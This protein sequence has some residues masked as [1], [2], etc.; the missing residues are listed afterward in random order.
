MTNYSTYLL[1]RT[2]ASAFIAA[3]D[4]PCN[5]ALEPIF[6]KKHSCDMETTFCLKSISNDT[7]YAGQT[8]PASPF[9]YTCLCNFGFYIPNQ[10]LHG[11]EGHIV[12]SG[13]G[14]YSCIR[15]PGACSSCNEKGECSLSEVHEY[16]SLETLLRFSIGVILSACMLCC[17]VLAAVVFKRRKCK[18]ISSGMWTVLE[19]I[20]FGILLM[21]AAVSVLP[22][23]PITFN[24][25]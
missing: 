13:N 20:L 12:E 11:F 23:K 17:I 22:D 14:N 18:T 16:I 19:T 2:V 9:A 4:D 3:D 24:F 6:G 5:D 7:S 25:A 8:G 21:Y 15:C 1:F 10:T